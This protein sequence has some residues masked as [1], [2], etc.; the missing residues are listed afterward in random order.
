ALSNEAAAPV[1]LLS[2]V[3]LL[4]AV[5]I[6]IVGGRI[7]NPRRISERYARFSGCGSEFLDSLPRF[8]GSEI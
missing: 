7:I 3:L 1:F 6:G 8:R 5:V 4:A 2:G